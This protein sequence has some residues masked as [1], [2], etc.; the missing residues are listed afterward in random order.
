[1]VFQKYKKEKRKVIENTKKIKD[2]E[3]NIDEYIS[4]FSTDSED[5]DTD[6]EGR[7]GYIKGGYHPVKVGEIYNNKYIIENKLGYG[8]YST[9]WL[10]T[11]INLKKEDKY[12]CVAIKFQKSSNSY[13]EAA[14]VEIKICELINKNNPNRDEVYV[15][16]YFESFKHK[17]PNGSHLCMVYEM[18]GD[19]LNTLMKKYEYKGLPIEIVKKITK[20]LL[21]GFDFLHKKCKITHTDIKPENVLLSKSIMNIIKL[22]YVR[23]ENELKDISLKLKNRE[24]LT[25]NKKRRLLIKYQKLKK[26]LEENQK[27]LKDEEET[28]ELEENDNFIP[29]AKIAD[30]GSAYID[31]YKYSNYVTTFQY[32]APEIVTGSGYESS[33]DIW[34][35]GCMVFEL[36]TGEYLFN[37]DTDEFKDSSEEAE[38]DL[39][40]LHIELLGPMPELITRVGRRSKRFFNKNGELKHI[41]DIDRWSIKGLLNEKYNFNEK[42]SEEI[43]EFILPMLNYN[44]HRRAKAEELLK[45]IWLENNIRI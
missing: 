36:L 8:R 9:V 20:N 31:E 23:K 28:C 3:F 27:I 4:D 37:S 17:G 21:Y 41:T 2:L 40:S 7:K 1:M 42:D 26:E 30:F 14:K 6:S 13:M 18:L 12:K 38:E 11:N 16:K 32:R 22:Q 5:Y 25:K 39:L 34:A 19:N 10:G 35:L 44:Y 29:I 33:I 24:K 45:S 15:T 43:E